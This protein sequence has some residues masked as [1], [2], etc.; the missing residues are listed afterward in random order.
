MDDAF[1]VGV[2]MKGTEVAKVHRF[3]RRFPAVVRD[4]LLIKHRFRCSTPRAPPPPDH[5]P[6]VPPPPPR[7]HHLAP[8]R[9]R[10]RP[11]LR[12]GRANDLRQR[13]APLRPLPRSEDRSRPPPV[14]RHRLRTVRTAP[15]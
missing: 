14:E 3:G 2:V 15:A 1:L 7:L 12:Q 9:A 13:T 6:P 8:P 4:A 5:H 11:A 10:P